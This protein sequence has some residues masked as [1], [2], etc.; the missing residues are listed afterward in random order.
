MHKCLE[1]AINTGLGNVNPLENVF[2]RKG[3]LLCFQQLEDVHGLGKNWNQIE[4]ANLGFGQG[5]NPL[6]KCNYTAGPGLP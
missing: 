5:V 3:R 2:Q 1:N 6:L 4:P